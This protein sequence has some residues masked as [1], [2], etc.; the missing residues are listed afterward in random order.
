M[1][2]HLYSANIQPAVLPKKDE[3]RS[4]T[5]GRAV[6]PNAVDHQAAEAQELELE[7]LMSDD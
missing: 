6:V 1:L 2:T 5:N 7:G 4:A 3:E